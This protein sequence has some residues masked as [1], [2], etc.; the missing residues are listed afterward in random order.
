MGSLHWDL[1]ILA[2]FGLY[3]GTCWSEMQ[4]PS[5]LHSQGEN[6]RGKQNCT[7]SDLL[8]KALRHLSGFF[9]LG[10]S[11]EGSDCER[12][13]DPCCIWWN[14]FEEMWQIPERVIFATT[15]YRCLL[16]WQICIKSPW[17][18]SNWG[19]G[20]LGL[21]QSLCTN[22]VVRIGSFLHKMD[23]GRILSNL[24]ILCEV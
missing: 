1:L 4:N 19:Y 2:G 10:R 23:S 15:V 24:K 11:A 13:V 17:Q 16:I 14:S 22:E 7:N 12:Q 5:A 18:L 21:R 20:V 9:C 3:R 8:I 6:Q